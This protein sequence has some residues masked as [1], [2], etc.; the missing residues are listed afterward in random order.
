MVV[1]EFSMLLESRVAPLESEISYLKEENRILA[2]KVDDLE[3]YSRRNCIRVAGVPES[4][5]D[6]TKAILE[7]AEAVEVPLDKS[8]IAVSHRVGKSTIG[9]PRQI[10]ARITN[11]DLKHKLLKS[12]KTLKMR[13]EDKEKP[14]LTKFKNVSISQDLT[15]ERN[16]AAYEARQLVRAGLA[17][18]T[19]IW[20]GKIFIISNNDVKH[21]VQTVRDVQELVKDLPPRQFPPR[22]G[23]CA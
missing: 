10:I 23:T 15:K 8:D 13:V 21:K 20:D 22:E 2:Q 4:E 7:I 16:N 1:E 14:P 11:Y 19:F 18:L 17:K 9:K 12:N 3:M 5:E 6:T